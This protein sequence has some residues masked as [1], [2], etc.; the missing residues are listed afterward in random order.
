[1]IFWSPT[2]EWVYFP[3]VVRA[4]LAAGKG[5]IP[6][7]S[8]L[9]ASVVADLAREFADAESWVGGGFGG[10]GPSRR[11]AVEVGED[12]HGKLRLG[13]HARGKLAKQ[14]VCALAFVEGKGRDQDRA[15]GLAE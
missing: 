8:Q 3:E 1:M 15:F 6:P 12:P 5:N 7:T 9:G 11:L 14:R 4:G 13:I 10:A 2:R